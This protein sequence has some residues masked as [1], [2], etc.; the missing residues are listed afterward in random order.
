MDTLTDI[1]GQAQQWLFEA[2]LQPLMFHLGL[3]NLLAD[4]YRATG[5][6]LVGLLQIAL[7]LTLMRALERWRPVEAITDRAAVRTDVV[8]TLIHR[9][10]LVRV[11]LD[12]KRKL[13]AG[14]L[15]DEP[16]SDPAAAQDSADV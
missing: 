11:V 6:L 15:D 13:D 1:F 14:Q 4:G 10:G 16:D 2:L 7:M 12:L 5:W 8:S 3:G 9:L